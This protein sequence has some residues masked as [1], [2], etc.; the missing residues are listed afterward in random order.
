MVHRTRK[1]CHFHTDYVSRPKPQA[2]RSDRGGRRWASSPLHQARVPRNGRFD[3]RVCSAAAVRFN[4]ERIVC[5]IE[6]STT[7]H[8]WLYIAFTV[9]PTVSATLSPG[10]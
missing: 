7:E 9:L 2:I 4:R 8:S 6:L 10:R 3:H 1:Q 5:T